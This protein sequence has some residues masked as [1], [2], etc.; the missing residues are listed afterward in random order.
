MF[1][2]ESLEPRILLSAD[3][4]ASA[5][6][7][8]ADANSSP[9]SVAA[10]AL[11]ITVRSEDLLNQ[12]DP[13]G[14][15]GAA[16]HTD[17]AAEMFGGMDT[18]LLPLSEDAPPGGAG[19]NADDVLVTPTAATDLNPAPTDESAVSVAESAPAAS[20]TSAATAS[21]VD[22]DT[23]TDPSASLAALG[24]VKQTTDDGALEGTDVT[25]ILDAESE[26]GVWILYCPARCGWR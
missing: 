1:A 20:E 12:N 9:D 11:H 25:S 8:T 7:A 15:A 3:L 16:P 14:F 17:S 10:D 13:F 23:L 24:S 21:S 4:L 2:L 6:L 18:E 22:T 26:F 19:A 5:T